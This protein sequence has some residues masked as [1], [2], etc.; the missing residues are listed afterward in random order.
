VL[1]VHKVARA[2]ANARRLRALVRVGGPTWH[3]FTC[4]RVWQPGL[5]LFLS[6]NSVI[7]VISVTSAGSVVVNAVGAVS[8]IIAVQLV[9]LHSAQLP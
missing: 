7:T 6:V 5:V 1:G 4:V 9:D 3:P 8:V 2:V